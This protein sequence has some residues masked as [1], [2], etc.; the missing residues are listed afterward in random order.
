M[1]LEAGIA[2]VLSSVVSR[3]STV[4][5]CGMQSLMTAL[6]RSGPGHNARLLTSIAAVQAEQVQHVISTY[7]VALFQPAS[8]NVFVTCSP[9]K[10]DEVCKG[11]QELSWAVDKLAF[12]DDMVNI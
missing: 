6:R 3:E 11:M 10:L 2:S 4:G 8:A 12:L 5:H 7:L 9:S 1:E